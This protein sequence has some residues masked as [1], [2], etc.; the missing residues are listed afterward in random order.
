[1]PILR[2]R[3]LALLL[4]LAILGVAVMAGGSAAASTTLRVS[5]SDDPGPLDPAVADITQA[6]QIEYLTCLKPFNFPDEPAENA[7]LP[8]PEAAAGLPVVSSDGLTYRL[9]IRS[10]L[11]FPTGEAIDATTF[12]H[13]LERVLAPTMHS[14]GVNWFSDIAGAR[15]YMAGTASDVSGLVANGQD[16]TI[17]LVAP[18]PD[19][20]ARLT[21]P[22]SCAVPRNTPFTPVPTGLPAAGPYTPQSA[23]PGSSLV[24]TR[25]AAYSG[26]RPSAFDQ[27]A[28][29]FGVPLDAAEAQVTN[30]QSDYAATGIPPAD[31]A[32][33]IGQYGPGSPAAAAGHQ[34]LFIS[35]QQE[36]SYFALNAS[37]PMF[38]GASMRQAV[39]FAL[40]RP[41]LAASVGAEGA[42]VSDHIL[43]PGMPGYRSFHVYPLTG[44]NVPLARSLAAGRTGTVVLYTCLSDACGARAAEITTDLARIGL[45]VETH[46]Y[47]VGQLY[48]RV[49]T[50]GEP[51]DIVDAG[52]VADYPDPFDEINTLLDG[53]TIGATANQDIAYFHDP[54]W[55]ARMDRAAAL[56]GGV[57]Y[58]AYGDLDE[59]LTRGPAPWAVWGNNNLRDFVSSAVTNVTQSTYGLDLAALRAR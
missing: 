24:L 4:S 52:W 7:G 57:R 39:N 51:F 48:A 40:D 58:R 44:P 53:R 20:V 16:L 2:P 46:R 41:A 34:Q 54:Y 22:F 43:P 31:Y 17:T 50:R 11:R 23:T 21:M 1:M 18:R 25:N 26:S 35:P 56:S 59:A 14:P 47:P 19:F 49:S 5:E 9:T 15:A 3:R 30:G 8:V 12:K 32:R 45:T 28:F 42:R 38:A 55:E 36:V 10:G 37:R 33:V 29:S 13:A 27:I 6:W